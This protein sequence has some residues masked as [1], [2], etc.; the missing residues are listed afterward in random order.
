MRG[1][2]NIFTVQ[3]LENDDFLTVKAGCIKDKRNVYAAILSFCD[4]G[5]FSDDFL[6]INEQFLTGKLVH[7]DTDYLVLFARNKTDIRYRIGQRDLIERVNFLFAFYGSFRADFNR[8]VVEAHRH[9]FAFTELHNLR[10]RELITKSL[11]GIHLFYAVLIL[12]R[13]VFICI[14]RERFSENFA[15]GVGNIFGA[16]TIFKARHAELDAFD[17]A[18]LR[19]FNDLE[20][21]VFLRIN[22]IIAINLA[23]LRD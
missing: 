19:R 20:L 12:G 5:S 9:N 2:F 1:Y 6:A 14:N 22:E 13:A 4:K 16:I 15:C 7:Q 21:C 10:V 18:V 3:I 17:Y 23:I 8:L 11:F